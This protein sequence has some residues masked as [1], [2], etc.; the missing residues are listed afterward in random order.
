MDL[1]LERRQNFAKK[2]FAFFLITL[3]VTLQ[4]QPSLF[5]QP[6]TNPPPPPPVVKIWTG[7]SMNENLCNIKS[8]SLVSLERNIYRVMLSGDGNENGQKNR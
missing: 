7:K 4:E 3:L 8:I 6:P 2:G 5:S 1:V